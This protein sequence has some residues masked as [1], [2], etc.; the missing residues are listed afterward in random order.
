MSSH[1][2]LEGNNFDIG[3]RWWFRS[4]VAVLWSLVAVLG[5]IGV[6]SVAPGV[7]TDI[8]TALFGSL[9]F[10]GLLVVVTFYLG[11]TLGTNYQPH[12]RF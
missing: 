10:A 6:Y 2:A 7:F 5:A 4:L 1:K 9:I 12:R 11:R 8:P 3:Q